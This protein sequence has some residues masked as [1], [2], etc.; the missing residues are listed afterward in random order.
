[1]RTTEN[2]YQNKGKVLRVKE[3]NHENQRNPNENHR[4]SLTKQRKGIENQKKES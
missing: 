2:H 1:M 3:K 4:E